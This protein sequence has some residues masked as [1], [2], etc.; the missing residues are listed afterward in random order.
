MENYVLLT[1]AFLTMDTFGTMERFHRWTCLYGDMLLWA[2]SC[3]LV[4]NVM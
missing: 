1:T 3:Y 2:L 4:V